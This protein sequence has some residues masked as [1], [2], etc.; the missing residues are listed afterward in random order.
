MPHR[1]RAEIGFVFALSC[2]TSPWPWREIEPEEQIICQ[3][4]SVCLFDHGGGSMTEASGVGLLK[5]G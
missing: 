3:L 4:N 2:V 1:T 5:C